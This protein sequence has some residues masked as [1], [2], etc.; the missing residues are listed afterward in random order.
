[1]NY[2]LFLMHKVLIDEGVSV[3]G[4]SFESLPYDEQYDIIPELYG[5][6]ESHNTNNVEVDLLQCLKNYVKSCRFMLV[7]G[8]E[9]Y[10]LDLDLDNKEFWNLCAAVERGDFSSHPCGETIYKITNA[11]IKIKL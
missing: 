4:V 5:G 1:M 2:D 10:T 11:K 7:Y 8:K 6:F 9:T 3:N